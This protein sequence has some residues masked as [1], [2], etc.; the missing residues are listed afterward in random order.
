M[1]RHEMLKCL[2]ESIVTC[3]HKQIGKYSKTIR[4]TLAF[5]VACKEKELLAIAQKQRAEPKICAS[6][7]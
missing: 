5:A 7:L 3:Q 4:D 6:N 2:R 1:T